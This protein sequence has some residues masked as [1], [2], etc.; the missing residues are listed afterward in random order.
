[1]SAIEFKPG[2]A[3]FT[4]ASAASLD[5]VAAALADRPA[6]QVTITGSA[7]AQAERTDWQRETI[8]TQLRTMARDEALSAGA[9]ASAPLTL[10][11]ARRSALLQ[12][13]YKRTRL[14]DKPRNLVGM[15]KDLPDAEMEKLL[16]NNVPV[17]DEAM[18]QEALARAIA[19]R[20]ALIAKGISSDRLFLAAPSLHTP[21]T[22]PW[23][24]R[25][26]LALAMR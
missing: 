24:P 5:K 1:M 19:V 12:A 4:D 8:E 2:T 6:L 3:V 7:D 15:L 10:T 13:L 11:P 20:D 25:A 26:T 16:M 18:R 14:P 9:P 21:G 17:D 23:T 22:E